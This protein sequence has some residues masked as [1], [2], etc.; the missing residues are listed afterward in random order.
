MVSLKKN[1]SE[2]S[3]GSDKIGSP[4]VT[5]RILNQTTWASRFLRGTARMIASAMDYPLAVPP[6]SYQRCDLAPARATVCGF[7]QAEALVALQGALSRSVLI[8][9][10]SAILDDDPINSGSAAF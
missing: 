7:V 2:N 8:A 4:S 1:Q 10:A 6:L 5:R 3:R 9:N